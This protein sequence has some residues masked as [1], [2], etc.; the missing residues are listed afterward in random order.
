ME[1]IISSDA[2]EEVFNLIIV[3]TSKIYA[4]DE[5]FNLIYD[6]WGSLCKKLLKQHLKELVV[7]VHSSIDQV[8]V[9]DIIHKV[10]SMSEKLGI[11]KLKIYIG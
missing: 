6:K 3:Q 7:N 8:L 5:L 10:V 1:I 9:L 11:K 4:K 2:N